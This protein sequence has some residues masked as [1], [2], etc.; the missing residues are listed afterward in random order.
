MGGG[1]PSIYIYI[2]MYRY[3]R[4]AMARPPRRLQL[5][6]LNSLLQRLFR[7]LNPTN[8]PLSSSFFGITL[9]DSNYKPQ[10]GNYLGACG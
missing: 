6:L 9:Q 7:I 3:H 5:R 1:R 10:K 2:Y 8:R 4:D